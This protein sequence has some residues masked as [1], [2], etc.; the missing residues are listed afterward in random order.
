MV[1][2]AQLKEVL[3]R[4]PV[5]QP[6]VEV[7]CDATRLIATVTSSSFASLDEADRQALVWG[8][9]IEQLGDLALGPVE[10]VFTNAP[11]EVEAAE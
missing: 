1:T 10:F 7:D 4:L 5:H 3:G 9:L 8:H 2:E 6:V 11:G